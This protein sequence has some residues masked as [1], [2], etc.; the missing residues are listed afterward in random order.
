MPPT[1]TQKTR[2]RR[3]FRREKG[4]EKNPKKF[5]KKKLEYIK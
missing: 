4:E 2:F 1:S 5:N 3:I